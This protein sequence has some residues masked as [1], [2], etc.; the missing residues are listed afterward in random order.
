MSCVFCKIINQEIKAAIVYEDEYLVAFDDIRP[1]A[2]CHVVVIPRM[3]MKSIQDVTDG[4]KDIMG[5]LLSIVPKIAC[6]KKIDQAGYR[7]I[8]NSGKNAGQ[9]VFHMHM[10]I[11]GGRKFSW[12][13]G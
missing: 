1:Q 8:I 13:P 5:R 3:H 2:P 6:I 9:E 10:H 11:L 4:E 7:V 12:P